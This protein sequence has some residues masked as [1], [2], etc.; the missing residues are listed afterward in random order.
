[1]ARAC[2]SLRLAYPKTAESFTATPHIGAFFPSSLF[3]NNDNKLQCNSKNSWLFKAGVRRQF[4][5][6]FSEQIADLKK[7]FICKDFEVQ[8]G[9]YQLLPAVFLSVHVCVAF[10]VPQNCFSFMQIPVIEIQC[11]SNVLLPERQVDL[12]SKQSQRGNFAPVSECF[13]WAAPRTLSWEGYH[14]QVWD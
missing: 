10:K 8:N 6:C 4:T 9:S 13:L 11:A 2:Y 3:S 5:A 7:W 1:M 14:Y 12:S